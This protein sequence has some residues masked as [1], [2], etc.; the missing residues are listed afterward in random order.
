MGKINREWHEANRMPKNATDEE[1]IAWH[2]AH[3]KHCDCRE[4][5]D[6]V[7]AL[8]KKHGI[9]PPGR[10][11]GSKAEKPGTRVYRGNVR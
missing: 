4:I 7:L 9:A 10:T 11:A 6:G 2:L 1:R 8:F 3:A 5:P